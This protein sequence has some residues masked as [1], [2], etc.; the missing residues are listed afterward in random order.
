MGKIRGFRT[1]S[2]NFVV[3]IFLVFL[4]FSSF[5]FDVVNNFI[6]SFFYV[7]FVFYVFY[8]FHVVSFSSISPPISSVFATFFFFS[9]QTQYWLFKNCSLNSLHKKSEQLHMKYSS[10]DK[11]PIRWFPYIFDRFIDHFEQNTI[12]VLFNVQKITIA[13]GWLIQ[14]YSRRLYCCLLLGFVACCSYMCML[15]Q[16][17]AR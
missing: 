15:D 17:N 5:L 11:S 8:V 7:F 12:D 6:F 13:V 2:T 1:I 14:S 3:A 4:C 10:N 9:H 16:V